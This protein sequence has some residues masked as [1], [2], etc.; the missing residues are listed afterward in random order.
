MADPTLTPDEE[1]EN[2]EHDESGQPAATHQ[3]ETDEE[4][5]DDDA[6]EDE[7]GGEG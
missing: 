1:I 3:H 6:D 2:A 5:D 4:S 7:D